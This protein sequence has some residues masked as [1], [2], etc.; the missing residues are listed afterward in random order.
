[1]GGVQVVGHLKYSTMA[2][3]MTQGASPRR[4]MDLKSKYFL[5]Q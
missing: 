4:D 5:D 3:F 2:Y 1:M